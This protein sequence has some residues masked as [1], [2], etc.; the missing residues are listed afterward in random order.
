MRG[1]HRA[2]REEVIEMGLEHAAVIGY[3]LELAGADELARIPEPELQRAA[4]LFSMANLPKDPL[5]ALMGKTDLSY[6]LLERSCVTESLA[7]I[8]LALN[9]IHKSR[10]LGPAPE[11][12]ILPTGL[13]GWIN[14][15]STADTG[16]LLSHVPGALLYVA[17]NQSVIPSHAYRILADAGL[18]ESGAD[19]E[20]LLYY[21]D[22]A[23][24]T[25]YGRINDNMM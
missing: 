24:G 16:T 9:R 3:G 17:M 11:M 15:L 23:T 14:D 18:L 7:V 8:Q 5:S 19:G 20:P 21:Y 4:A 1:I 22:A 12:D 6:Q 25:P 10:D 2:P 13:P